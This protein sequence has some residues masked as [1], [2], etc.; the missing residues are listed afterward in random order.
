MRKFLAGM[1]A[2]IA[3]PAVFWVFAEEMLDPCGKA[4]PPPHICNPRLAMMAGWLF[5]FLLAIVMATMG[6]ALIGWGGEKNG[7]ERRGQ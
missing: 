1:F 2:A 4:G 3:Y 6:T 7:S 5:T